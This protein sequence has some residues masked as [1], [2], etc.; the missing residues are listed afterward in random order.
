[1]T[2]LQLLKLASVTTT[3]SPTKAKER[4][5]TPS[6]CKIRPN[7]KKRQGIEGK[8]VEEIKFVK[9]DDT[10]KGV[11]TTTNPDNKDVFRR[12]KNNHKNSISGTGTGRRYWIDDTSRN[13]Y[14]IC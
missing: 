14:A 9:A 6:P 2:Y 12:Y 8:A 3:Y 7:L 1:M 10:M 11:N 13:A 5:Y 4:Y